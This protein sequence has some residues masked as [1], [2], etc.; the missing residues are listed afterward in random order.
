MKKLNYNGEGWKHITDMLRAT[1]N[2][3]T[4]EGVIDCIEKLEKSKI[5]KILRIQLNF[6]PKCNNEN[7]L[8]I[9]YDYN[10]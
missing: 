9:N 2:Y 4:H 5:V 1:V 10:K 8:I 3:T 6:G 7:Y